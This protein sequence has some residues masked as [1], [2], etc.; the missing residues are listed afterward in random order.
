[1]AGYRLHSAIKVCIFSI[2][3]T[4][5]MVQNAYSFEKDTIKTSAGDLIISFIGHGTLMF[6]FNNL[7]IHVD[8]TTREADYSTLP[9]ADLVLITHEHGDHLD[10]NALEQIIDSKSQVILTE[11]CMENVENLDNTVVLHNGDQTEA[12]GIIVKAIPAYNILNKRSDGN[13]YHPKGQGNGYVVSFGNT[14]VYIAGD[15]ENTPEMKALK[16]IHVAFL[17]MN[18]PYTMTPE[19]VADAARAF[20]PGILYPYHYGNTDTSELIAL[21]KENKNI[22]IRIRNMK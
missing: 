8:P 3:L 17:S 19:M 7:V 14:N 20:Q 5:I 11:K 16:N 18:L 22:E 12:F 10:I 15:T 13:P 9:K 2:L 4:I 6:K 21:L 1:M